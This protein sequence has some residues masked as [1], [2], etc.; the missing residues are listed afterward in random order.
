M[1]RLVDTL[2]IIMFAPLIL[3]VVMILALLVKVK[4]GGPVF[5]V[6]ERPGLNEQVFRMVK[7]R[8]MT[9]ETDDRGRLLADEVRLTKFGRFLRSTS[10]DELPEFWNVIRGEMSLVGPRPLL[11]EYLA[12]YNSEQAQRHNVRPGITGWAQINGRNA[13]SWDDKFKLDTWYVNNRTLF[14]DFK[15]LL[16]TFNKVFNREGVSSDVHAT[17]SPFC[18]NLN[19]GEKSE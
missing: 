10:L 19:K 9:N 4:L 15:I 11:V 2:L 14:L 13:L 16:L 7:F 8:S 5:F 18:G 6:Q 12:L 1:K 17:M 3:P